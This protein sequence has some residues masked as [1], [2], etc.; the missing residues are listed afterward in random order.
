MKKKTPKRRPAKKKSQAS[1]APFDPTAALERGRA[2]AT[3]KPPKAVQKPVPQAKRRNRYQPPPGAVGAAADQ[4]ELK[5]AEQRPERL[6]RRMLPDHRAEG[7]HLTARQRRFIREYM[8]DCNATAAAIRAGYSANCAH[9]I[10]YENL[11]KPEI[12]A[13]IKKLQDEARERLALSAEK[14]L[15]RYAEIAFTSM[16]D[17]AYVDANGDL[18]LNFLKANRHQLAAIQELTVET[19]TEGKGDEA[20]PVKRVKVKLARRD[21][22]LNKLGEHLGIWRANPADD[23]A[24]AVV[25]ALE[26]ARKRARERGGRGNR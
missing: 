3:G 18:R 13:A 9:Q 6:T 12:A 10:G 21:Q 11:R 7:Q 8:V 26:D 23:L 20:E 19:Y 16:A 5:P 2:K 4:T 14:V 1:P 15:D 17:F 24:N 25:N 22:A